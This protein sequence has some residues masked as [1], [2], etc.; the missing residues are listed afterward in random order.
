[1]RWFPLGVV[2]GRTDSISLA[3]GHLVLPL[4]VT[5]GR[6]RRIP[7]KSIEGVETASPDQLPLF[8]ETA[9][10]AGIREFLLF[11]HYGNGKD[12]D[13]TP[14]SDPEGPVQK[15]LRLLTERFSEAAFYTH[16]SLAHA[17]DH[18]LNFCLDASGTFDAA[19]TRRRFLETAE[20]HLASGAHGVL[21]LF[22]ESGFVRLLRTLMDAR[23]FS[24]RMVLSYGAKFDSAL[25]GPF[26][27]STSITEKSMP[28]GQIDPEDKEAALSKAR[29]DIE[30]GT[31][32]LIIKPA[33]ACLD[34]IGEFRR[35]FNAPLAGWLVSGEYMMIKAAA[36]QGICDE[37]RAMLEIHRS[38]FRAGADRIITYDAVR[39]ARWL[40]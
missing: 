16:L 31:S 1:M 4:F 10:S 29:S 5:A 36:K 19:K 17:T 9:L 35:E 18:G 25:Y 15:A 32:A 22:L 38:L 23:G 12:K 37:G 34:I 28:V 8:V 39:L 33:L 24:D 21:P 7:S 3:P 40:S 27:A 20:S 6:K 11:G 30:E 2:L 26:N 13:G 14:A